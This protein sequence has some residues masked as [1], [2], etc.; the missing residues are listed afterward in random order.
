VFKDNILGL[1]AKLTPQVA[2]ETDPK[3]VRVIIDKEVRAVLEEMISSLR[4]YEGAP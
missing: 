2:A 4:K 1:G 3:K